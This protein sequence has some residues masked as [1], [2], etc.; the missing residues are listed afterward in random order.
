M[1]SHD[2]AIVGGGPVG[3][4]LGL[5]AAR[6]GC[7]VVVLES[8]KGAEGLDDRRAIALSWGSVLKLARVGIDLRDAP[9]ATPIRTIHVSRTGQPGRTVLSAEEASVPALGVVVR[10]G[11]LLHRL[12][13]LARARIDVRHG[14]NVESAETHDGRARIRTSQGEFDARVGVVADGGGTLLESAG[15]RVT[16][17]DYGVHAVVARVRCDRSSDVIAYERFSGPGPIALLPAAGEYALIWTLPPERAAELHRCSPDAFLRSLQSAFGWRAGRFVGVDER[18][19]YPLRSRRT[20]PV[21]QDRIVAVGNAAQS[22]HP[23]AGQGLN[24]G[25]RDAWFLADRL[26][27]ADTGAAAPL[28]QYANARRGDRAFTMGFTDILARSF[29]PDVP[30]LSLVRGAALEFLDLVPVARRVFART[31][32]VATIH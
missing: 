8:R 2:L 18:G 23:V 5:A 1:D 7:S 24:L 13:A 29:S 20:E 15:F 19:T 4:F 16:V 31:L 6:R 27:D 17:Q 9:E 30:G 10:Y 22:L 25:V 3:L 11:D 21:V 14:T 26:A 28:A 12:D 32:S